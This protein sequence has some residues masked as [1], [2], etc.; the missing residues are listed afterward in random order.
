MVLTL[1][2]LPGVTEHS[3]QAAVRACGD[4]SPWQGLVLPT[5]SHQVRPVTRTGRIQ[6]NQDK[7]KATLLILAGH[8]VANLLSLSYYGDVFS[9][10]SLL[11][12]TAG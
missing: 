10:A 9:A 6:Q 3:G 2:Q 4:R 1:L 7:P 12:L 11:R 5:W 8:A